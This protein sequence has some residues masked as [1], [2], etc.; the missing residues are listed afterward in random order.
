MSNTHMDL[1][2]TNN[3]DTT[4]NNANTTMK[5][6]MVMHMTFYGGQKVVIL[7]DQ[8]RTT[9]WGYYILS[10]L[11]LFVIAII[12]QYLQAKLTLLGQ[13]CSSP[14][15]A[16]SLFTRVFH[17]AFFAL[18]VSIA[19]FL[20]LAMMTFNAGVFVVIMLG[21][22]FG[23]FFFHSNINNFSSSSFGSA[24]PTNDILT[25]STWTSKVDPICCA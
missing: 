23:F 15:Y 3:S 24:V 18:T 10:L 13:T 22:G 9:T 6:H 17:S 16:G 14:P 25:S 5:S 20:M 21:F 2:M 1:N 12:Y 8:W 7:F 11:A 4:G 19:Y